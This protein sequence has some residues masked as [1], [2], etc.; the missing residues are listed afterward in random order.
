MKFNDAA[1]L[2]RQFLR[3][4]VFCHCPALA[5]PTDHSRNSNDQVGSVRGV[6]IGLAHQSRVS[7][8]LAP[9]VTTLEAIL[10]Q[11]PDFQ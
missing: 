5:W 3:R 4:F 10:T 11:Y 8:V 2:N 9:D 1:L 7:R 6:Q